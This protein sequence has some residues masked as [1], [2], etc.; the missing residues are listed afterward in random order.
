MT[1]VKTA[2]QKNDA[3][4]NFVITWCFRSSPIKADQ[5]IIKL[6]FSSEMSNHCLSGGSASHGD[7]IREQSKED[8][9]R[10]MEGLQKWDSFIRLH[11]WLSSECC[12]WENWLVLPNHLFPHKKWYKIPVGS[13]IQITFFAV[14]RDAVIYTLVFF[15]V[16][17]T[18]GRIVHFWRVSKANNP[19]I[20]LA[21]QKQLLADLFLSLMFHCCVSVYK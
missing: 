17:M 3:S 21:Q 11:V 14:K 9:V 5:R 15:S 12:S 1:V 18:F 7:K 20:I 19:F 8:G 2:K 6:L 10:D 16:Q 13:S 4:N